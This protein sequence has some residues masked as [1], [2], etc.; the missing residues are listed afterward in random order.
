MSYLGAS[1]AAGSAPP[2]NIL[3]LSHLMAPPSHHF[4]AAAVPAAV[5]PAVAAAYGPPPAAMAPAAAT[6]APA[7]VPAVPTV[8][9]A[10]HAPP[11]AA[12]PAAPPAAGY[13]LDVNL[14]LS[15]RASFNGGSRLYLSEDKVQYK[16]RQT[17]VMALQAGLCELNRSGQLAQLLLLPPEQ[18]LQLV[19]SHMGNFF[20]RSCLFCLNDVLENAM[21]FTCKNKIC[22][23]AF[24]ARGLTF[25]QCISQLEVQRTK[26][27]QAEVVKEQARLEQEQL[28]M[29]LSRLGA[30]HHHHPHYNQLLALVA[31]V[32][33][34]IDAATVRINQ[35]RQ[36]AQL[37]AQ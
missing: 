37:R 35:L 19:L 34:S 27:Q 28:D 21:A 8:P 7:T 25:E 3:P 32:H 31:Q 2:Y 26:L 36:Q 29:L 1:S 5:A 13:A 15:C 18:Q 9:A 11:P 16:V 24:A 12:V 20:E 33:S 30:M 22:K 4:M 10:V 17:C 6:V 14:P 23:E